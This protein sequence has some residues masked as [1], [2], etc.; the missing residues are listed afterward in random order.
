MP[1]RPPPRPVRDPA[2][3]LAIEHCCHQVPRDGSLR[4][5]WTSNH[6]A[7]GRVELF[8][9][10]DRLLRRGN[11]PH[12]R[13]HQ[14]CWQELDPQQDYRARIQLQDGSGQIAHHEHVCQAR[15]PRLSTSRAGHVDLVIAEACDA[16]RAAWPVRIGIPIAPGLLADAYHAEIVDA[17]GGPVPAQLQTSARWDDGSV[18]WLLASFLAD[19]DTDASRRYRLRW[20]V[21]PGQRPAPERALPAVPSEPP[22]LRLASDGQVVDRVIWDEPVLEESGPICSRWCWQGSHQGWAC[23]CRGSVWSGG[24]EEWDFLFWNDQMEPDWRNLASLEAIIPQQD[25]GTEIGLT[26]WPGVS[27]EQGPLH[28]LQEDDRGYHGQ[29]AGQPVRGLRYEGSAWQRSPARHTQIAVQ[30]FWQM[31]PGSYAVDAS[32]ITIGLLPALPVDFATRPERRHDAHKLFMWCDQ[33]RYR[34]RRGQATR[35]RILRWTGAADQDP[36]QLGAWLRQELV[37]TVDPAA[38]CASGVLGGSLLPGGSGGSLLEAYDHCFELAMVCLE[39]DREQQRTWGWMHFGDWYGE[40]GMNYG[41][42]EYDTAWACGL[43]WCRTGDARSFRRGLEMARHYS[44]VDSLHGAATELPVPD[45]MEDDDRDLVLL[46]SINHVGS[47]LPPDAYADGER[48]ALYREELDSWRRFYFLGQSDQGH[49]YQAGNWLYGQLAGDPVLLQVAERICR[50]LATCHTRAFDF[51]IERAAGWPINNVLAAYQ[52]TRDPYFLNAARIFIERVLAL[53]DPDTG[54]WPFDWKNEGLM[55]QAGKPFAVGILLFGLLRY[56]EFQPDPAV[57]RCLKLAVHWLAHHAWIEDASGMG[58]LASSAPASAASA[59]R[60]QV[61][62][63]VGEKRNPPAEYL[64]LEAVA[65]AARE[66]EDPQIHRLLRGLL[67]KR[68]IPAN[69][70]AQMAST[71]AGPGVSYG[72]NCTGKLFGEY[73]RQAVYGVSLVARQ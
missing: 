61:E 11:S 27:A 54:G 34:F 16:P 42:N 71:E 70:A 22:Q 58:H 19:T 43:H 28:L 49:V 20:D 30:D 46:H 52:H 31:A 29:L 5:C 39:L 67:N 41:N 3:A 38:V 37:P 45:S 7:A 62:P 18:Q 1:K 50:R 48:A 59:A 4:L 53:Q 17:S 65:W 32:A 15:A 69:M 23:T 13:N 63:L 36:E 8:D 21:R 14:V 56:R 66:S 47:D 35:Q 73:F 2:E 12:G 68:Y 9:R 72:E 6:P 60:Q 25:T 10:D 44:S 40:R 26:G 33:G 57:D 24:L 55:E 64:I 51:W